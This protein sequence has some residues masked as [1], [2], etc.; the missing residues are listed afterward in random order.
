M[1]SREIGEMRRTRKPT[2][3]IIILVILSGIFNLLSYSFDQLVVQAELTNRN[4]ERQLVSK[5]IELETL[6]YEITTL[7]D[8]GFDVINSTNYF[9]KHLPIN[10]YG[11]ISFLGESP[12][13]NFKWGE[14]YEKETPNKIGKNFLTKLDNMIV[15]FNNKT[16]EID[17]IFRSIYYDPIIYSKIFGENYSI[18]DIKIERNILDK[19]N[20]NFIKDKEKKNEVD[21]ANYEIYNNIYDKITEFRNL[22]YDFYNY[23]D[24]TE[25]KYV[26]KFGSFLNFV[27]EYAEEQ[28]KINYFI[29]LSII[30]QIFGILFI[31]L[32][33]KTLIS[34]KNSLNV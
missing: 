25:G 32:L 17:N 2:S 12:E 21:D 9:Y 15:Y 26:E 5:R 1:Q 13:S 28:N 11:T 10:F 23:L 4:L 19:F 8:L 34:N 22:E 7:N 14:I 18:K 31:L 6:S 29:L 16:D 30:S 33:F 27:D 24:E 20:P 3:K